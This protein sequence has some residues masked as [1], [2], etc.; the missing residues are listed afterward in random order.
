MPIRCLS[1]N[2][3]K[4]EP[5]NWGLF[6]LLPCNASFPDLPD[7]SYMA[8]YKPISEPMK[9]TVSYKVPIA[10]HE[11]STILSKKRKL[12]NKQRYSQ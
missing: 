5:M 7:Y 9:P 11:D 4:T 1:Y 8:T 6:D 3:D 2:Y 10:S 12:R